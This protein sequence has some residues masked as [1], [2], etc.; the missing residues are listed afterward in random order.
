M[1]TTGPEK[2]IMFVLTGIEWT[3]S[4]PSALLWRMCDATQK[5]LFTAR[6]LEVRSNA[7]LYA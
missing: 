5:E 3:G 4:I 1:V 2:N 7:V 6:K